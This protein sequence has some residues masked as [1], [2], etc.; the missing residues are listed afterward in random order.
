MNINNYR[1]N[2]NPNFYVC[3]F[4]LLQSITTM[5]ELKITFT[6]TSVS[7]EALIAIFL[8]SKLSNRRFENL[9]LQTYSRKSKKTAPLFYIFSRKMSI[10]FQKLFNFRFFTTHYL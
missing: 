5:I 4:I 2:I 10:K 3:H 1:I 9:T 6:I 8:L 7:T